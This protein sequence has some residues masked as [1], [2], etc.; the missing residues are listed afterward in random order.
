MWIG[1]ATEHLASS[2]S[3]HTPLTLDDSMLGELHMTKFNT[4]INKRKQLIHGLY[5]KNHPLYFTWWL[6]LARCYDQ[7]NVSY[8]NYG[9]RGISVCDR[10]F[11]FKNFAEDMGLKPDGRLTIERIENN[12]GY[13]PENCKWGT[14]TEQSLNRRI[15]KNNTTGFTGIS[16]IARGYHAKY[17]Y[18][19]I[20]YSIGRFDEIEDA[21][22]A[23]FN[24][25]KTFHT[26]R[27]TAVASIC[28]NLRRSNST[29][30]SGVS[31]SND[32]YVA[33]A[34]KD[35]VR[36]YLGYSTDL[37][38]TIK[39][40]ETY[41]TGVFQKPT[42]RVNNKTGITGVSKTAKGYIVRH[43]FNG[44]RKYVGNFKT[45][46]EAESALAEF[47]NANKT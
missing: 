29:G 19:H 35:G 37:L 45:I 13:S 3:F 44:V 42:V 40:L 47:K 28:G 5:A 33:R 11:T 23:R 18:N 14:R 10:W 7:S 46:K 34:Y 21:I 39:K 4:V 31:K 15:F 38:K 24:F 1:L 20:R 30:V 41:Y 26:D 12:E 6:M 8:K 25:I 9:N 17:D 22:V 2:T 32:G 36:M 43:T 16:P 27:S